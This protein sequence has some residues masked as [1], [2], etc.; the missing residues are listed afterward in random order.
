MIIIPAPS[1]AGASW[2][3][4]SASNAA[5]ANHTGTTTETTLITVAI[6]ANTLVANKRLRVS[7]LANRR[8]NSSEDTFRFKLGGTTYWTSTSDFNTFG[9]FVSLAYEIDCYAV[10]SSSQVSQ[11]P[12]VNN[13]EYRNI[14]DVSGSPSSST[15][16]DMTVDV[17]FTF[18]VQLFDTSADHQI[19][20]KGYRLE[21]V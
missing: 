6:P 18:T 7:I 5:I 4:S 1:T 17:D 12:R 13:V 8:C 15:S 21:I 16:V 10:T 14:G 3:W 20:I 11:P 19:A 9:G 2:G